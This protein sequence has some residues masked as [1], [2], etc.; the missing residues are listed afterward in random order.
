MKKLT[1]EQII[2]IKELIKKGKKINEVSRMFKVYPNSIIYHIR[3]D[4]RN[5]LREYNRLRYRNMTQEHKKE[6]FKK[7]REYQREYQRKKYQTD[8]EF[9]KKQIERAK[10]YQKKKNEKTN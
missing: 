7:K 1:K 6:Y 3:P 5:K 8:E 4:F 10:K 9:R 2:K